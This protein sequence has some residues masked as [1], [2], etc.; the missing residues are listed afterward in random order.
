[1]D[2]LGTLLVGALEQDHS[3]SDHCRV[4]NK[5]KDCA[6]QNRHNEIRHFQKRSRY[7]NKESAADNRGA[8]CRGKRNNPQKLAEQTES[9][10]TNDL[11][12]NQNNAKRDEGCLPK[13]RTGDRLRIGSQF[14][15]PSEP[16][17]CCRSA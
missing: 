5:G 3:Y 2:S 16:T 1:M 4:D 10:A 9:P 14:H 6:G 12:Q 17:A 13:R 15:Q 7:W 8:I 11:E